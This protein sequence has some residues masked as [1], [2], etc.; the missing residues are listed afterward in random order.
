M[1][2]YSI[3]GNT[4][5][6]LS[7]YV[8]LIILISATTSWKAKFDYKEYNKKI[9]FMGKIWIRLIPMKTEICESYKL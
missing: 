9:A 3:V 1:S 4:S 5:C 6:Q 2:G 7:L 8:A